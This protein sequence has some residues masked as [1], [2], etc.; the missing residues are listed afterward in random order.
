MRIFGFEFPRVKAQQ[1]VAVQ[2]VGGGWLQI[3]REGF[4]GAFSRHVTI[5][6]PRDI[7]AFSGVFAPLTLIAGDIAK[8]RVKLV[9]ED[10][11][12]ICTEIETSSPFLAVLRKPNHYQNRIQFWWQW[13]LSKLLWGN[14]YALKVRESSRGMVKALYILDPSRVK[15][16]VA[17]SGDVWY[18]LSPDHLSGLIETVTVPASEIIHD[19]WNC[20]WHPLVGVSP[21]YACA[22]SATHGRRIQNQSTVFFE[23]A[24]RPS[25]ILVAPGTISDQDAAAYKQRWEENYGGS[26]TGRTAVL[27]NGL[28][29][30]SI[31]APAEQSQLIEQLG[32]TKFDCADCFHV[33]RF[34]VG[35]D[36]PVGSTIEA[37]NLMYYTDCLQT[38]I[39]AAELCLDQGLE[40]KENYYCEFDI[41][42]LLRMDQSSQMKLLTDGVKGVMA[43]NE[44][45]KKI[46]L[47]PVTGGDEVLTQQ[48]NYSLEA[49]AKRDAKDDPFATAPKSSPAP[50]TPTPDREAMNDDE[51]EAAALADLF[52]QGL[53][54]YQ[55]GE[56]EN[57][58]KNYAEVFARIEDSVDAAFA[59][60]RELARTIENLADTLSLPVKPV[61]DEN[62]IL[63]GARRVEHI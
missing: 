63:I 12:G 60:Q 33:P 7:L 30:E 46:N 27:G 5:D 52:I 34:K 6:G 54:T 4:A 23:N 3:I 19:R 26:G 49:L 17:T 21:I 45:R 41:D 50:A 36:V 42:G 61:Y 2:S 28:K 39:E 56:R 47:K 16:L 40:V 59:G 35:G 53:G 18:E 9:E 22:L 44:A 1:L 31:S 10:E 43:A 8:L 14:T 62:G 32:W 57:V 51:M 20:L 29:Y 48:Q 55:F 11:D 38:L 58:G 13:I 24:S 37:L 25:G 15:P